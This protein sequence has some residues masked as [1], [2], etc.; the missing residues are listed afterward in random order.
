MNQKL[1]LHVWS[2]GTQVG[3]GRPIGRLIVLVAPVLAMG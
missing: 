1:F 2:V 3:R